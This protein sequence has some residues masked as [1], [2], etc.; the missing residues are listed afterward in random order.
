M[1]NVRIAAA[2][3]AAACFAAFVAAPAAYAAGPAGF[4]PSGRPASTAP[5][6]FGVEA[7]N[8]VADVL[9][10]GRDDQRVVLK[11]K[12]TKH[13]RGDKYEF[14]DASGKSIAAELDDDR[15]WSMIV[16]DQPVEIRAKVDRDWTSTELEVKSARAIK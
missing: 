10:N 3:F 14:T 8:T 5:Q 6:G 2:A 7:P 12:F 11:G 13:I 16:K 9:E 4:E 1:T 15:D